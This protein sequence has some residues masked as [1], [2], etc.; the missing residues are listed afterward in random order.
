MST[1]SQ[2]PNGWH[3]D[4]TTCEPNPCMVLGA[5]CSDS[6]NACT[7]TMASDCRSGQW[8]GEW[9]ECLPNPCPPTAIGPN[10][11]G[12]MIVHDAGLLLS[13]TN[14]SSSVCSQ[15]VVPA[16]CWEADAQLEGTA[17]GNPAIFKVYAAF[18]EQSNPRLS[19]LTWGVSY[20]DS[21]LVLNAQGLCAD[22]EWNDQTWPAP[23]SG[24]SVA[25]N[26]PQ[27]AKLVPIYWFAGYTYGA[28]T[29]FSLVPNPEQGGFFT[30]DAVPPVFDRIAAYG[31][32]GFGMPGVVECTQEGACCAPDGS[33]TM[34]LYS[35]CPLPG[36]WLYNEASC[37]PDPCATN[38][39][40]PS[41]MA[42]R[43]GLVGITPNPFQAA[44]SIAYE[45][46]EAGPVRLEVFDAS[47]R[48]VRTLAAGTI[49]GGRHVEMWNGRD[50]GGSPVS[51]GVYFV[52]LTH[53][54]RE[55]AR[56]IIRVR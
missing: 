37:T 7:L 49:A 43:S 50:A 46:A 40:E 32:L 16:H 51:A 6:T 30:S 35:G 54:G 14:S 9:T 44:A 8:H 28:A 22:F 10:A 26:Q 48:M 38:T 34:T 18:P 41:G 42:V 25:W 5:C 52:R 23:G 31:S 53:R 20:A 21:A 56:Q 1:P 29:T 19:G 12:T 36:V 47:G 2:C 17:P 39:V 45:L 27:T 55:S 11:R 4:W 33:C 3:G 13:A 15:G 24:S